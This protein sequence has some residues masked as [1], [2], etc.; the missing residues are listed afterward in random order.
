MVELLDERLE[1]LYLPEDEPAVFVKIQCTLRC[2]IERCQEAIAMLGFDATVQHPTWSH[3][4]DMARADFKR[5]CTLC[6][7]KMIN[8]LLLLANQQLSERCDGSSR[9]L[10]DCIAGCDEALLLCGGEGEHEMT[11]GIGTGADLSQPH[12]DSEP[13]RRFRNWRRAQIEG[14][15]KLAVRQSQAVALDEAVL[16]N[17]EGVGE[18]ASCSDN[19]EARN[20]DQERV[21]EP[22]VAASGR[23][24]ET[25]SAVNVDAASH[26]APVAVDATAQG[27]SRGLGAALDDAPAQHIAQL[28]DGGGREYQKKSDHE[29]QVQQNANAIEDY[30]HQVAGL[31]EALRKQAEDAQHT[32]RFVADTAAQME[33]LEKSLQAAQ[34]Q[35]SALEKERTGEPLAADAN[36]SASAERLA[37]AAELLAQERAK[38]QALEAANE[39]LRDQLATALSHLDQERGL[40]LR[41]K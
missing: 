39:E 28:S 10:Q 8:G 7:K 2:C 30:K 4:I 14:C 17:P 19:D 11:E 36:G 37:A 38:S 12:S 23:Q 41:R 34:E 1:Q 20:S 21:S 25:D 29:W 22:H 3:Q 26:A 9:A 5:M 32:L 40:T 24:A 15:R 6:E 33:R 16:L 35:V 27:V 18:A 31:R 13:M